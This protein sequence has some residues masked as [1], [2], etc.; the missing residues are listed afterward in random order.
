VSATAG[1][2]ELYTRELEAMLL[3]HADDATGLEERLLQWRAEVEEWK[4]RFAP[5]ASV[6]RRRTWEEMAAEFVSV[7]EGH[8]TASALF[9][10]GQLARVSAAVRTDAG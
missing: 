5:L 9:E 8:A 2:A 6:L 10:R 4:R 3:P 1:V 7:V